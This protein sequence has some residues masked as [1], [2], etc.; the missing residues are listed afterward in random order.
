[1]KDRPTA[2]ILQT[3]LMIEDLEGE[4]HGIWDHVSSNLRYARLSDEGQDALYARTSRAVECHA[5]SMRLLRELQRLIQQ[6][7]SPDKREN[8]DD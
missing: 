5:E 7:I 6:I 2:H 3:L 4:A 1:M 8:T